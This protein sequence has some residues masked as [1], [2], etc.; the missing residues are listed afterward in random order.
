VNRVPDRSW[1]FQQV[2]IR[3]FSFHDFFFTKLSPDP[4]PHLFFFSFCPES[5]ASVQV[6]GP[7]GVCFATLGGQPPKSQSLRTSPSPGTQED[8]PLHSTDPDAELWYHHALLQSISVL[9]E[10]TS[11]R[12]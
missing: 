2:R 1:T 5:D 8:I 3:L 11:P 7:N 6:I 10:E 9:T 12:V 4:F